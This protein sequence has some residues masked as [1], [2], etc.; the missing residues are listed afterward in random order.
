MDLN[1]DTLSRIVKE[2]TKLTGRNVLYG[3]EVGNNIITFFI[4]NLSVENAINKLALT[5]GLQTSI[6]ED[7]CILID[8]QG[9]SI[10]G[11]VDNINQSS[12]KKELKRKKSR[13]ND[14]D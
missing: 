4:E 6:T 12:N 2:V 9:S 1:S 7:S 5:N 11:E 14:F 8:K 10:I 3:P 13:K